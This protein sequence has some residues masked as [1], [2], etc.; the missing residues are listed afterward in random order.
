MTEL[1]CPALAE[2]ILRPDRPKLR[3]ARAAA[4]GISKPRDA[5]SA[6]TTTGLVPSGGWLFADDDPDTPIHRWPTS[7]DLCVALAADPAGVAAADGYAR[8]A[9]VRLVPWGADPGCRHVAWRLGGSITGTRPRT[10]A[11]A[12]A[13]TAGAGVATDAER[14]QIRRSVRALQARP[15]VEALYA[16][17]DVEGWLW[18]ELARRA[19]APFPEAQARQWPLSV[20]Q[21]LAGRRFRDLPNPFEP[22]LDVWRLGYALGTTAED[23]VVVAVGP[24]EP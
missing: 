24:L 23:V 11:H 7:V 4:S 10:L 16:S 8:E 19:D 12:A 20:R 1:D 5:W 22:L 6:L 14:A 21:A 2:R 9:I 18:W 3:E 15:D 13:K 17:W